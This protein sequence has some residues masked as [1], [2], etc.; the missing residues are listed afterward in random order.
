MRTVE[1][2]K[3]NN[4]DY[5]VETLKTKINLI[6]ISKQIEKLEFM[7][8]SSRERVS[9]IETEIKELKKLL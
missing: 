1:F 6:D 5:K 9:L 2:I 4:I 8:T 3:E 7:L